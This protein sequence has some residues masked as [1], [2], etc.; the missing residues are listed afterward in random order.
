MARA[1]K[2]MRDTQKA[3]EAAGRAKRQQDFEAKRSERMNIKDATTSMRFQERMLKERARVEK[4]AQ[5][6]TAKAEADNIA[7][8]KRAMGF[9]WKMEAQK[10]RET[11]ENISDAKRSQYFQIRMAQQKAKEELQAQK[12]LESLEKAQATAKTSEERSFNKALANTNRIMQFRRAMERLKA[13]ETNKAPSETFSIPS[14]GDASPGMAPKAPRARKAASEGM[15]QEERK[16]YSREGGTIRDPQRWEAGKAT[17][18]EY[19]QNALEIA[20]EQPKDLRRVLERAV[21]D[22][23]LAKNDQTKREKAYFDA[24]DEASPF[25]PD[26]LQTVDDALYFLVRKYQ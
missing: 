1:R 26:A 21:A 16:Q 7:T 10:A 4:E 5:R 14:A 19:E 18:Q 9:Q 23:R 12:A 6:A 15:S 2:T 20:K 24:I 11:S 25:G 17:I 8:A 3:Q 13:A 22:M